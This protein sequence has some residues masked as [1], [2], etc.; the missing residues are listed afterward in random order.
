MFERA[1]RGR[2]CLAGLWI[3]IRHV[4]AG[5]H[6][7]RIS[8]GSNSSIVGRR[9]H[10][11]TLRQSSHIIGREHRHKILHATPAIRLEWPC[12]P[13]LIAFQTGEKHNCGYIRCHPFFDETDD[14]FSRSTHAIDGPWLSW[15]WLLV[16]GPRIL[17]LGPWAGLL[18]LGS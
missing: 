4:A 2:K 9:T 17:T 18:A 13:I 8:W 15:P 6:Y 14:C 12:W 3:R 16:P 5:S 11:S 7:Q 1:I 10:W